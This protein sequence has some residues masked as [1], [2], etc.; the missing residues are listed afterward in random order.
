MVAFAGSEWTVHRRSGVAEMNPMTL[1]GG[2][3]KITQAN[4][5]NIAINMVGCELQTRIRDEDQFGN[6]TLIRETYTIGGWLHSQDYEAIDSLQKKLRRAIINVLVKA[7]L[8][9]GTHVA[10]VRRKYR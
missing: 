10:E 2:D 6:K 9:E 5:E 8:P 7:K 3:M 1:G 4:A